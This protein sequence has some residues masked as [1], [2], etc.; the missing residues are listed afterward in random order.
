MVGPLRSGKQN[1]NE[2]PLNDED[3]DIKNQLSAIDRL[4]QPLQ[5]NRKA[6][7]VAFQEI[8]V[9][10]EN[11][12]NTQKRLINNLQTRV[13]YLEQ[14]V[15]F[16]KHIAIIQERQ[17]VDEEQYSRESN[18][19]IEGIEVEIKETPAA[20]LKKNPSR[21]RFSESCGTGV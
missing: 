6:I 4:I 7:N 18:L 2:S 11:K 1:N 10:F 15:N 13:S 16:N 5:I 8:R 3:I 14:G 21:D 12:F 20:I 9:I 17:I 19:F